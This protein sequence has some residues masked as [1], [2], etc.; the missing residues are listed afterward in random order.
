MI[1]TVV[2]LLCIMLKNG[3]TYFKNLAMSTAED[4]KSTFSHFS[5][6]CM[7]DEVGNGKPTSVLQKKKVLKLL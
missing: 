3:Q 1:S 7:E 5:T 2:T 6:L 4:L